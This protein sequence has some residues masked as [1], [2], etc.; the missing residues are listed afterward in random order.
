[1]YLKPFKLYNIELRPLQYKIKHY[2]LSK[3]L[4]IRLAAARFVRTLR[5]G[6]GSC[7]AVRSCKTGSINS[8]EYLYCDTK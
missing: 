6:F 8:T 2:K 5:A 7:R 1:M 3:V 4:F